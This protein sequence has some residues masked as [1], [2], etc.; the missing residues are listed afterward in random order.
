[1]PYVRYIGSRKIPS[2]GVLKVK[3]I[4]AKLSRQ[5]I[6]I[7]GVLNTVN[8]ARFLLNNSPS[9]RKQAPAEIK[10]IAMLSQSGDLFIAPL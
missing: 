7:E 1:M 4:K 2:L 3:R 9:N 10:K 8:S 5:N 6:I